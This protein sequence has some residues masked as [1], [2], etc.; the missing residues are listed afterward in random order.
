[1]IFFF[2]GSKSYFSSNLYK[3][4]PSSNANKPIFISLLLV[5]RN[6]YETTIQSTS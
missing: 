6:L 5:V 2:Y 1:M 4:V 3:S